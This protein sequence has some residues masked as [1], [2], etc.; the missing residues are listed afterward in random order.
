MILFYLVALCPNPLAL[1]HR[2]LVALL[3][4]EIEIK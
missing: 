4:S 3:Q 2:Q 1:L